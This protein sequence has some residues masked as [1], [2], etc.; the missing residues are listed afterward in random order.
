MKKWLFN[1]FVYIAGAKSLFIGLTFMA[2]T[3]VIGCYSHTHFDGVVDMHNGRISA[4]PFY[5][6]EQ[7]IDWGTLIVVFFITG[8]IFSKSSIRIIDVA[9]TMA[10]ARWVTIFVA[11]MGFGINAPNVMPH[12]TDDLLKTITPSFVFFALLAFVFM[13]WMIALMYNAFRVSCN[14]KGSQATGLFILSLILA[15][16]ISKLEIYI[17]YTKTI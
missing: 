11:I 13:I 7:L 8:K 1:P 17:L 4:L 5:L 3:A 2:A 14:M 12:S 9:G 10:M 6:W 15:E 16:I